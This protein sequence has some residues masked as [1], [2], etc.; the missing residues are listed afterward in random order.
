MAWRNTDIDDLVATISQKEVDAFRRS[1]DFA[2]DP[3][4]RLL[5]RTVAMVRG[6]IR[7]GGKCRLSPDESLIPESTISKAMDYAAFDVLKRLSIT[8]NEARSKARES[9]E[10][11]FRKIGDGT[12]V[13]ESY[14]SDE[15]SGTN[16]PGIEIVSCS[17]ARITPQ[18]VEGL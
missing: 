8:P 13:P 10:A 6:Y 3:V 1:A 7:S 11:Y 9:A 5:S 16:G 17:R 14:G 12:L 15:T 4:E 18:S 2:F